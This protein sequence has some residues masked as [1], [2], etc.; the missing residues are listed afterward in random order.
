MFSKST[1]YALRATLYIAQ[2]GSEEKKIGI[3]EVS[4]A[5]DSPRSFTAKILQS[6]T[7]ENKIISSI[8]GPHGGF[9]MTDKAKK[10][11]VRAILEAMGEDELLDRCVLGL[12]KCSEN[13][14]C[15]MHSKYKIIKN[16]LIR[17]FETETILNLA[18]DIKTGEVFIKLK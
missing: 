1:E 6:L 16:Q 18:N 13:K 17:L 14:P 3:E 12:A 4:K 9:Y 8:S 7:K 15:P 10:L 11:P 2:K 5:I